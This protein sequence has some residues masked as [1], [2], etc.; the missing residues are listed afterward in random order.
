MLHTCFVLRYFNGKLLEFSVILGISFSVVF[1][2]FISEMKQSSSNRIDDG[3]I[4]IQ[5]VFKLVELDFEILD[6][7]CIRHFELHTWASRLVDVWTPTK[8]LSIQPPEFPF[9]FIHVG[10]P[11][12]T[13]SLQE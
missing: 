5:S 7:L 8:N 2:A 13:S 1:A 6:P 4:D 3:C 11:P 9:K 10:I 12:L